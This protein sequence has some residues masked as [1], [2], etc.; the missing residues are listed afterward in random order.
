MFSFNQPITP[1]AKTH[2]KAQLSFFNDMSKA[3]FHSMQKISDLNMHLTHTLMEE[4]TQIGSDI[5]MA[6]KPM[7][8][9]AAAAAQ[10]HPT[11]DKLRA[12]QQHLTRIAA[13]IQVDLT[14]CAQEHVEE[15]SRTAKAMADEAVKIVNEET[16]QATQHTQELMRKASDAS[17]ALRNGDGFARQDG[18]SHTM[19]S[20]ANGGGSMQGGSGSQ[21]GPE[22]RGSSN[23]T[24]TG[25]KQGGSGS[26][27]REA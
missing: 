3:I 23:A 6:Q 24:Q 17:N 1:A 14:R 7:E 20:D 18:R 12:Y 9:L 19:Q 11:A 25:S 15:T 27:R 13:D 21:G 4:S 26:S 8:M 2:M 16:E 10:A 22:A 5:L